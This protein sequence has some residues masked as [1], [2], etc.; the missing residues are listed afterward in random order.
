MQAFGGGWMLIAR[1]AGWD[2]R[3]PAE[4]VNRR[5]GEYDEFGSFSIWPD[6]DFGATVG[7]LGLSWEEDGQ[8][9]ASLLSDLSPQA[10]QGI[11]STSPR[12]EAWVR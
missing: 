7:L 3:P 9:K 1:Q 8:L 4:F 6:V 2:R 11:L 12:V 5:F 10:L